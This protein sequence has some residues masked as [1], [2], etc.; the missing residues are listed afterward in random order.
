MHLDAAVEPSRE[1]G[2][3]EELQLAVAGLPGEPSGDE[4]RLFVERSARAVELDH[5]RGD[6]GAAR[7]VRRSRDRERG[8]LD[9]DGRAAAA[10][11]ER[12]ERLPGERETER[13]ANGGRD[14]G[15]RLDRG[16]RSEHDGVLAGVHHGE[17][18]A[19]RQ[20]QAGQAS[21]SP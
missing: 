4:Q 12:L 18:R 17:P 8:R 20:R 16:R 5:R 13:V 7:V 11:D 14:V 10:R 15:D 1:L 21:M 6:R 3:N 19:V 9:D 2:V